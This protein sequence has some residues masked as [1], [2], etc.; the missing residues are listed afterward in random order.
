VLALVRQLA[1][2]AGLYTEPTPAPTPAGRAK[3]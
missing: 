2:G 1:R 3:G